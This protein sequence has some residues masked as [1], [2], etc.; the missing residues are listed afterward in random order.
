V[1]ASTGMPNVDRAF[2]SLQRGVL[3]V[4]PVIALALAFRS[5]VLDDCDTFVDRATGARG[6]YGFVRSIPECNPV[7]PGSR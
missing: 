1:F 2:G 6:N 3:P 7:A 5:V 4:T